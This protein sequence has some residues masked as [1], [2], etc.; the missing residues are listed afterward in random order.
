MSDE[1]LIYMLG[2]TSCIRH[3]LLKLEKPGFSIKLGC[4]CSSSNRIKALSPDRQFSNKS[5]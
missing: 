2:S 3:E 1:R 4:F 5:S